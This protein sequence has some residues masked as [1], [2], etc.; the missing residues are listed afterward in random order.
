[1]PDLRREVRLQRE[2]DSELS[3]RCANAAAGEETE[4]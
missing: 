4:G 3:P 2:P 1:M